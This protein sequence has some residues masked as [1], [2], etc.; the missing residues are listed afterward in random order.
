MGE[1]I[2]ADF[3]FKTVRNQFGKPVKLVFIVFVL[4]H[5]RYKYVE[6]QNR[7]FTT[8]DVISAHR[9]A[10]KEFGG[11][12]KEILYDQDRLIVVSENEGDILLTEEFQQFV[13]EVKFEVKLCR[14]ADPESKGKVENAVKFIKNNF[15]NNRIF[16]NIDSWNE[17]SQKWL[18]RTGNGKIHNG[19]KRRPADVFLLEKQHMR[20]VNS[21]NDIHKTSIARS[22]RKDNTILYLSNRYSVPLGTFQKYPEVQYYVTD[23]NKIV[24]YVQDSGEI[25]ATHYINPDK[26]KLIQN[27]SHKRDRSKGIKELI[28]VT[29]EHFTNKSQATDYLNELRNRYPRYIRDQ[30]SLIKKCIELSTLELIDDAL[31][32]C[33]ERQLFSA[34]DFHDVV[35]L[36]KRQRQ[37]NSVNVSDQQADKDHNDIAELTLTNTEANQRPLEHYYT[38]MESTK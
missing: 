12:S 15:I 1:Q 8:K 10:F 31:S 33:L 25:L 16:Y 17:Q 14:K 21:V 37:V 6:Y 20:Q 29:S 18:K 26:G 11:V 28:E 2:Q 3:G 19:T 22:V 24:I 13:N 36:F 7:P 5:S 23:D 38:I 4:A 35:A 32:L 34:N 9:N 30:L 27:T